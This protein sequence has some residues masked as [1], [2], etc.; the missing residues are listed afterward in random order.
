MTEK[1]KMMA[2]L[3]YNARD[4][5]LI[6]DRKAAKLMCHRFN[7]ADPGDTEARMAILAAQVQFQG[8]AHMEPSFYC[9]YGYNITLGENFYA[10][11]NLTILDVCPVRIGKNAFIG[12][13]VMISAATHPIDPV[14]RLQ[15]EDGAPISIGDNVWLGGNVS[16]LPG[17]RIGNNCVIGAGSV[18]TKDIPDNSVAAGNPCRVLRSI[19]PSES[20]AVSAD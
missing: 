9:D 19:T 12:P 5:A 10:N 1:E 15:T 3:P 13:N 2:G 11:H 7:L 16:V 8:N 4:G 17:I 20:V 6:A 18:V 14:E